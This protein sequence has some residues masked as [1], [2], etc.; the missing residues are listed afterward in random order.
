MMYNPLFVLLQPQK[1][2]TFGLQFGT[3][4]HYYLHVQWTK[5]VYSGFPYGNKGLRRFFASMQLVE[6][7]TLL[8]VVFTAV[9]GSPCNINPWKCPFWN[10]VHRIVHTFQEYW[11]W[12]RG[13]SVGLVAW[14][15]MVCCVVRECGG[16]QL[17]WLP[18]E[19]CVQWGCYGCWC[20]P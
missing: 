5:S 2:Y 19:K 18:P 3:L 14:N 4:W 15:T 11:Y 12:R 1:W 9:A 17:P 7:C 16:R 10:F 8:M 13:C 6:V 20:V